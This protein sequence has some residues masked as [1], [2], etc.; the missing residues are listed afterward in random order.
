MNSDLLIPLGAMQ[1]LW[2]TFYWWLCS[3][4]LPVLRLSK[5]SVLTFPC[6]SSINRNLESGFA[7]PV[8]FPL[9]FLKNHSLVFHLAGFPFNS[10]YWEHQY[11]SLINWSAWEALVVSV[12]AI[13]TGG[14][15]QEFLKSGGNS[16]AKG[17]VGAVSSAPEKEELNASRASALCAR[18]CAVWGQ[19]LEIYLT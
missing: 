15:S 10:L 4:W 19:T 13:A 6:Y 3:S 8:L 11:V 12:S 16:G 9:D 14:L 1:T 17:N 7:L 5:S 2:C 18:A